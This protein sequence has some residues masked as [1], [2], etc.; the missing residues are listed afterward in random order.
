[1]DYEV[2]TIKE[3]W[4]LSQKVVFLAVS[5]TE[6][7]YETVINELSINNNVNEKILIDVSNLTDKYYQSGS[8]LSNAEKLQTLIQD[9]IKQSNQKNSKISVVK[10]FNLINAYSMSANEIKGN[11][12]TITIASDDFESKEYVAKLC[13]KI[14][15]QANDSGKL[16]KSLELEMSNRKT[17]EDW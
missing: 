9:K 1:M 7:V 4:S 13:N 11:I 17:F 12:E 2:T 15:Y 14:G 5:A 3:A 16:K 6:S 10:G 8:K